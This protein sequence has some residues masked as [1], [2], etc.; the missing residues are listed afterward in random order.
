MAAVK[1]A[2]AIGL[3]AAGLGPISLAW[4]QLAGLLCSTL[5]LWILVRWRPDLRVPWDLVRPMLAYGRGA[6]AVNVLAAVA[7][8][9]DLVIVGRMLGTVA[10]G[11][12]QVA[13][14]IPEATLSL[15]T[16]SVS[17]VAFPAFARARALQGSLREPY[18]TLLAHV[19][20]LA[21]PVATVMGVLAEPIVLVL[22]GKQW[23]AA[24]PVLQA[25]A[26][27]AAV[28]TVGSHA[29]DVLKATGRAGLLAVLAFA[30]TIVLLPALVLATR[31]GA[32]GVAWA[33]VVVTTLGTVATL[34][35][36]CRLESIPWRGVLGALRPGASVAAATAA[37]ALAW[38]RIDPGVAAPW[39]LA[40]GVALAGAATA[41]A[42]R[43]FAWDT[44]LALA[45]AW[46]T[47]AAV[48]AP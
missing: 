45:G 13:T 29:G 7:H 27:L 10:L 14:R 11:T 38:T 1:A 26:V 2:V 15:L 3:A 40:I 44:V 22:L 16:W 42:A 4:G 35:T 32:T 30:R 23:T 8:H 34:V 9:A 28:R 47:R 5:C 24:I 20:L 31:W 21:L 37:V 36:A 43:A 41:L 46:R 48:A 25:L 18:L 33:L 6:V 17:R 39:S 12:Y 19:A